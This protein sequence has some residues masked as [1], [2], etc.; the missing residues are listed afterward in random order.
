MT[1]YF[2]YGVFLLLFGLWLRAAWREDDLFGKDDDGYA[3]PAM[4]RLVETP[5]SAEV[6]DDQAGDVA[7]VVTAE[8]WHGTTQLRLER[9]NGQPVGNARRVH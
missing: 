9:V 1:E 8:E 7:A 2:G 3:D 4:P 6:S 5:T